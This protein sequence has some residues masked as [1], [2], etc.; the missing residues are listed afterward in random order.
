MAYLADLRA[1]RTDAQGKS[2]QGI[3]AQTSNFYLQDTKQFCRWM[4]RDRRA[5]ENPLAYL[6]GL[7]VRL[8][9][10]HDRR[11]LSIEEM[12]WLL[13]ITRKGPERY[14]ISGPE[15]ALLYWLAVETGL[16]ANE[17]A[18]LTPLSFDLDGA[19]PTVTVAAAYSKHRR[20]DV[21]P[22]RPDMA[23]AL[24]VFLACKLPSVPAFKMPGGKRTSNMMRAD[25]D[26]ARAA[27][28]A[29]SS[30]PQ[31]RKARE[32]TSFLSYVDGSDRYADFHALRH[33][34]I[35]NLAR[36]GAHPKTAQTLA[37]HSTITLTMDY[38]THTLQREQIAALSALPDL[39]T[40][41]T[42]QSATQMAALR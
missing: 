36:S 28:L 35:T 39:S 17:L 23:A 29:E 7:N 16:R 4:V 27:W 32:G 9:R 40:L 8:D 34:F 13:D 31:E 41:R 38:Y 1:D 21:L 14:S 20:Q 30:T 22:L 37:R 3:S 33:T 6:Q 15:R 19:H 11:A 24:R 5:S 18:S 12:L 10:R 26:Y 42:S 2:K 25:L